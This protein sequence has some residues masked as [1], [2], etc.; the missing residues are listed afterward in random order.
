MRI[1]E[2]DLFTCQATEQ[3]DC[4]HYCYCHNDIFIGVIWLFVKLFAFWFIILLV[5]NGLNFVNLEQIIKC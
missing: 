5:F 3:F 1:C 4:V 2:A